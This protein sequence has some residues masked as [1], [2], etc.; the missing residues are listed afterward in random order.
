MFNLF[1]KKK[2]KEAAPVTQA[3]PAP[4][5]GSQGKAYRALAAQFEPEELTILAVTGTGAFGGT[6]LPDQELWATSATL[7]A[8]MEE[9]GEELHREPISLVALAD[10]R[11]MG[12]LRQRLPPNFIIK[13]TARLSHDGNQLLLTNLPEPAFDPDLKAILEE[14]KKPVTFETE[15]MG[16]FTLRRTMG[17]FEAEVNWLEQ[18]AQLTIDEE[19]DREDSLSTA[20]ALLADPARWDESARACAARELLE[21]GNQWVQEFEDGEPV[22]AEEF[23]QALE[24]ESI[25]IGAQGA[26]SFCFNGG[27]LFFGHVVQVEGDLARGC[28]AAQ[29]E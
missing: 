4:E 20:R 2:E 21:L 14:Q 6:Q 13:C 22:S 28:T 9:D 12:F 24:L 19:G 29:G 1:G 8:W 11:L 26:F 7:T 25:Q 16:T 17:W 5:T 15:D 23:A 3:T 10:D 18:T 27:E